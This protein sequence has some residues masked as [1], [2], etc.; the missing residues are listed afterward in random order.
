MFEASVAVERVS[1]IAVV[2]D[3]IVIAYLGLTVVIIKARHV[4]IVNNY[5]VSD[6]TVAS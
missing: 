6:I 2:T 1:V 5:F 4:W 3:T